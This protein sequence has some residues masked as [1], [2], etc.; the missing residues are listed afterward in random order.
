MA[1][2]GLHTT[3]VGCDG[4]GTRDGVGVPWLGQG[5]RQRVLAVMEEAPRMVLEWHGWTVLHTTGVGCDGGGAKD[6]FGVPW[7]GQCCTQ[8]QVSVVMEEAPGM[9]LEC[10]GWDRVAHNKCWL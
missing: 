1:W 4:G 2:T 8:K 3:G 9:V 10:R 6:G 5:C 7:L